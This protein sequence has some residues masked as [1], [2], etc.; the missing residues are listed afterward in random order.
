M[1]WQKTA[2]Q[3][4]LGEPDKGTLRRLLESQRAEQTEQVVQLELRNT[5]D[6]GARACINE[7]AI[8]GRVVLRNVSLTTTQPT[9]DD[10]VE[11]FATTRN[12]L[13]PPP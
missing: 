9:R 6:E 7:N 8:T 10:L 3:R 1:Q 12:T 11:P 13:G 5:E 4:Y 2:K